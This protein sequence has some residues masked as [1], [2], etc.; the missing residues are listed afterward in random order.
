MKFNHTFDFSCTVYTNFSRFYYCWRYNRGTYYGFTGYV[1]KLR[2]NEQ[3]N[4]QLV[5]KFLVIH[6]I[7]NFRYTMCLDGKP[8][9]VAW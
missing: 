2:P 7:R 3:A 1:D 5:F 9:L 4:T 6:L 8:I